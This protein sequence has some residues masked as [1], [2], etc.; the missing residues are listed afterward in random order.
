MPE[1]GVDEKKRAKWYLYLLDKALEESADL[2]E[3]V[4]VADAALEMQ[5]APDAQ[6]AIHRAPRG[7]T[8]KRPLVI[9]GNRYVGGEFV[10]EEVMA[11]AT[12]EEKTALEGKAAPAKQ[13]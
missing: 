13:V 2:A 9:Q 7:Y 10:P 3:A 1:N 4:Q 5:P 8:S 11:K 6:F 12:P